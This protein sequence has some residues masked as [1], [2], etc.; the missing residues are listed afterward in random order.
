MPHAL[1]KTQ[2]LKK[3]QTSENGLSSREAQSRLRQYGPN[4]LKAKKITPLPIRFLAE[5][6]DLMVIILIL[7]AILAGIAGERIDAGVILFIVLLNAVIGFIQKFKAEKALQA[8]K[9]MIE[10]HAK[11]IRD[12]HEKIINA[13]ELVPGDIL[14]LEEGDQI[15]ADARLIEVNELKLDESTLTGESRP[16]TKTTESIDEK[17]LHLDEHENIIF[18]GTL[19]THGT[20]KA[21]V[22]KTGME[23]EFGKIAHLTTS[24]KKDLS[25]LEKELRKIGIFVGKITLVISAILL[26]TGTLLQGKDF[27]ETLLFA[28]SVAVAAVPE[29]LPATITIALALGVKRLASKNSIVKQLSSVETLGSTTVICSDKTGTITKNEMT[30][31]EIFIPDYDIEVHGVGYEPKGHLHIIGT[32]TKIALDSEGKHFAEEF[33]NHD[34]KSLTKNNRELFETL[35]LLSTAASLCNNSRLIQKGAQWKAIGDPTEAALLTASEKIGFNLAALEKNWKRQ[36]ELPFDSNRK[37]MSIVTKNKQDTLLLTKGAVEEILKKCA[38][39][40]IDGKIVKLEPKH[41]KAIKQSNNKM[42]KSA[43]RVLAFAYKPI[44]PEYDKKNLEEKLVFLGMM[45]M[46]DP[47]RPEVAEAVAKT[48]QAGIKTYIITGDYG[49]TAE[50]IARQVGIITSKNPRI[51]TGTELQKLSA[52]RLGKVL[53]KNKEIIF[54]RVSPEH[55]LKIVEALKKQGEIVAMTGDGV[56][57]APALKRADIGIAMGIA[58]TDVSREAANM[59]LADD[60]YGSIVTAIE[61]GRKIYQNLRKFIFYIFSCNIGELTTVFAA[62]IL[63]LPAPL[64]A[65]LILCVDLGTDVLPALALGVDKA[66]PDTMQQPPRNPK[67]H[68]IK[69]DFALHFTYLGVLIGAVVTLYFYLILSNGTGHLKAS[70]SAFALLVFIQMWNALNSRSLKKSVFSLGLFSNPYLLGAIFISIVTVFAFIEIPFIQNLIGTTHLNTN[71]W[72]MIIA[73]SSIVF[74]AEEGRKLIFHRN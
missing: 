8:L 72:L 67:E 51:I 44:K 41:I 33:E 39:I 30:V 38:Q 74:V 43:L 10:P 66:E 3:L 11:V 65:I 62:I 4:K 37:M 46:I 7:A 48:H 57:D 22:I 15:G 17:N 1:S 23:T 45:G 69:R 35:T 16:V 5:F 56:N 18:M 21:I 32:N 68:I 49:P 13:Y 34:L 42:A 24:T 14:I 59:V 55:K 64:T 20:A 63:A 58:G 54:S 28:T 61:E 26:I 73:V 25:P 60:S 40:K 70:T 19:V 2:L 36:L 52:P 50:A 47:P 12:G 29:G 31:K 9:N 27:I 6:K 53:K 71:E